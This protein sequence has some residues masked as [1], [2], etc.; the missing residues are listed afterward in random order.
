L[1]DDNPCAGFDPS[2]YYRS[3]QVFARAVW[4]QAQRLAVRGGS[5]NNNQ[6]NTRVSIRNN[7]HPNNRNNNIGFR[8]LA[9]HKFARSA[10]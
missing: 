3:G 9:F 5:W 2:F 4:A 7:N 8:V 6:D 1:Q 10:G